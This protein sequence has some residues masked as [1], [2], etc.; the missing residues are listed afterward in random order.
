MTLLTGVLAL[1]LLAS[2][3]AQVTDPADL[4]ALQDLYDSTDGETWQLW[5]RWNSPISLGI[6]WDFSGGSDPC[7]DHWYG[8]D[9]SYNTTL[10]VN[11]RVSVLDLDDV[12]MVGSLPS[13]FS[14]L[15][16]LTFLRLSS[17]RLSGSFPDLHAFTHLEYVD[18]SSAGLTGTVPSPLNDKLQYL[19][20]EGNAITGPIPEFV[21]TSSLSFLDLSH[22]QLTGTVPMSLD[23]PHLAE[24][25]LGMNTLHGELPDLQTAV[26]LTRI[27]VSNN[28]LSGTLPLFISRQVNLS[29]LLLNHNLFEGPAGSVVNAT[30]QLDLSYV[31]ISYNP[32]TG[33]VPAWLF[34]PLSSGVPGYFVTAG[35]NCFHGTL[36]AISC[37]TTHPRQNDLSISC[38]ACHAHCVTKVS[39]QEVY[40]IVHHPVHGTPRPVFSKLASSSRLRIISQAPSRTTR[41]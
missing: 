24:L 30:A 14:Q 34:S 3:A 37:N 8:I 26:S 17:N 31:D 40:F 27:D 38:L 41:Q 28:F 12:F 2:A 11:Y 16:G 25:H 33:Q 15:T 35:Y 29:W 19:A 18:L 21:A 13:S 22:N 7:V 4:S 9:C 10:N 20:A 36:P 5:E 1:A 6:P 23:L 32:I 39:S